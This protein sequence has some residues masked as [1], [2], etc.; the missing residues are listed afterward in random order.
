LSKHADSI[1]VRSH[2]GR[3]RRV[4]GKKLRTFLA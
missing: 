4:R 3:R 1:D 2:A